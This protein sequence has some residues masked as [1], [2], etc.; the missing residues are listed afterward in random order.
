[1]CIAIVVCNVAAIFF[2]LHLGSVVA[3]GYTLPL[4]DEEYEVLSSVSHRYSVLAYHLLIETG[5]IITILLKEV[6]L[7]KHF[8]SWH[9]KPKRFSGAFASRILVRVV[10]M[11]ST[12]LITVCIRDIFFEGVSTVVGLLG[13]VGWVGGVGGVVLRWGRKRTS[14]YFSKNN[15]SSSKKL[16]A[17]TRSSILL[18]LCQQMRRTLTFS[19]RLQRNWYTPSRPFLC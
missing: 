6:Y 5:M 9:R 14:I 10:F 7:S 11:G 15:K 4:S 17:N 13:W 8:N 16:L 19:D 12:L 1:M 2:Y 18:R 3:G